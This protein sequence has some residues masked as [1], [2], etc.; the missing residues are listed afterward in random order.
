LAGSSRARRSATR[1]SVMRR[2]GWVGVMPRREGRDALIE[3][4]A[5]SWVGLERQPKPGPTG[6][7]TRARSVTLGPSA[8]Q[9]VV[10][11]SRVHSSLALALHG[12][13]AAPQRGSAPSP[14]RGKTISPGTIVLPGCNRALARHTSPRTTSPGPFRDG[15]APG[16]GPVSRDPGS[17]QPVS[18]DWPTGAAASIPPTRTRLPTPRGSS[19]L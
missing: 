15:G 2:S 8:P 14:D 10:S 5:G 4:T 1:R 11:S 9:P 13:R 16:S 3:G 17:P 7:R 19:S 6:R 18:A 12:I